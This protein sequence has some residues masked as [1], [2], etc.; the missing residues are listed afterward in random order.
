[1]KNNYLK[2]LFLSLSVFTLIGIQSCETDNC[3]TIDCSGN[4]S[5][6]DGSCLCEEGWT[7]AD[8]SI[9]ET[10]DPCDGITCSNNGICIS[11]D[12]LCDDGWTGADC[13]TPVADA[14]DGVTCSGNGTCVSGVCECNLGYV[15]TDCSIKLTSLIAGTWNV[16]ES[17]TTGTDAYTSTIT[18]DATDA[19]K[20]Y[21]DNIYNFG[22]QQGINAA[23]ATVQAVITS[24]TGNSFNFIVP[25][26]NFASNTLSNF[27]VSTSMGQY[28]ADSD[29][30]TLNY[31]LNDGSG[32]NDTCD[33][34][35]NR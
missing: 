26:Q 4:G 3:S 11:G 22:S 30:I 33:Q 19:T 27:S 10:A 31:T 23:D 34:T 17:C 16:D 25:G 14:C 7:G 20:F 29:R 13:S 24:S 18:A 21:I 12:C 28:D 6:F 8:C 32:G 1:M 2:L 35:Y 9:P 5:C 15:G